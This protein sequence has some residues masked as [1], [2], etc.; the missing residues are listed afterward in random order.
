LRHDHRENILASEEKPV[1]RTRKNLARK[2]ELL[3]ARDARRLG[4]TREADLQKST[5]E[6]LIR[7][8]GEDP[9]PGA[10]PAPKKTVCTVEEQPGFLQK[11]TN[12]QRKGRDVP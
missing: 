3:D 4:A 8:K 2:I 6:N 10:T 11:P 5:T 12:A 9:A 7:R 1:F